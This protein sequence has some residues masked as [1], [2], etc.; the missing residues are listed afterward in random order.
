[1]GQFDLVP[2]PNNTG[3]IEWPTNSNLG[4]YYMLSSIFLNFMLGIGVTAGMI[5]LIMGGI[6]YIT[7]K[8]DIKAVMGAQKTITYAIVGFLVAVLAYAIK[9]I[10]L[11]MLGVSDADILNTP[12]NI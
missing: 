9:L 6:K 1:M 2:N 3:S 10:I 4:S 8:G 5:G 12:V 11:R 7:A